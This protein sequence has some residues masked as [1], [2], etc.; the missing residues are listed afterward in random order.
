MIL[1]LNYIKIYFS[2]IILIMSHEKFKLKS[3]HKKEVFFLYMD[4]K[5][6]GANIN[7]WIK[8]LRGNFFLIIL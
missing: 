3:C 2:F 5:E 7:F 6:N 8:L 4:L 1:N